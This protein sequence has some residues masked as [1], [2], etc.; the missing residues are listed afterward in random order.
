[1][2]HL[3]AATGVEWNVPRQ[4]SQHQYYSTVELGETKM[5]PQD[6]GAVL[7]S[8]AERWPGGAYDLIHHNCCHFADAFAVELGVGNIPRWVN[9]L[10]RTADRSAPWERERERGRERERERVYQETSPG[11]LGVG[12]AREVGG[13][14]ISHSPRN[15]DRGQVPLASPWN[16]KSVC[17]QRNLT[18]VCVQRHCT[19]HQVAPRRC[20]W[21]AG[22]AAQSAGRPAFSHADRVCAQGGAGEGTHKR[23]HPRLEKRDQGAVPGKGTQGPREE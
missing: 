7:E 5:S 20:A 1:M 12:R 17:V 16:L 18:S 14:R 23:G 13:G 21:C 8:L 4:H 9:R 15:R 11:E 3:R 10:A 22:G 6:V 2:H 19:Q